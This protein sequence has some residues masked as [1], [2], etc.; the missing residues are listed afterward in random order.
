MFQHFVCSAAIKFVQY[1]PMRFPNPNA[2]NK[3]DLLYLVY[4]N[5]LIYFALNALIAPTNFIGLYLNARLILLSLIGFNGN[6]AHCV[7][8]SFVQLCMEYI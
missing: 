1:I 6:V 4:L 7:I 5:Y 3:I 8:M 2:I